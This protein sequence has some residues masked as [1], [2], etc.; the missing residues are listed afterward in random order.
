VLGLRAIMVEPAVLKAVN[1]FYA[2]NLFS[3]IPACF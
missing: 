1:P 2:L 3:S